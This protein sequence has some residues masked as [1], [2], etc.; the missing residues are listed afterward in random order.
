M[1]KIKSWIICNFSVLPVIIGDILVCI[2]VEHV[3]L[4]GLG[5]SKKERMYSLV[6]TLDWTIQKY[7]EKE[8]M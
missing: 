2:K 8:I 6:N 5:F 4:S 3:D 7:I 1:F